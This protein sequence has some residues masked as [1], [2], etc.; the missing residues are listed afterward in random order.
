[1]SNKKNKQLIKNSDIS[2]LSKEEL[3][4]VVE[5]MVMPILHPE[6]YKE[7]VKKNL[8]EFVQEMDNKEDMADSIFQSNQEFLLVLFDCLRRYHGWG[9]AEMKKLKR[10]LS[11]VLTGAKEF[12]GG[13][14]SFLSIHDVTLLGDKIEQV[15]IAGVMKEIVQARLQRI[16]IHKLGLEVPI[17]PGAEGMLKKLTA[18]KK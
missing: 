5:N 13:G 1:M 3:V 11:D 2:K 10:E 16:K 18:P 14:L 7:M 12:E 8:P 6:K 17:L 15:G 4:K 9:E